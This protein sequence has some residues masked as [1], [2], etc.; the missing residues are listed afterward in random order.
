MAKVV[1]LDR[2]GVINRYPGDGNYVT[3]CRDFKLIPG[4]AE[5]IKKIKR[6]G[7]KIFVVSN[8]SGVAKGKYSEKTLKQINRRLNF[9]LWLRKTSIDAIYYCTHRN[10]DNCS[11]RKPKTGLLDKAIS[12]LEEKIELSFFIGDSFVDMVTA[13]N[14]GA[15]TILLLSGKEKLKNRKNW[16]F[17][18]DYIFDNLLLASNFLLNNYA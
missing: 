1:F 9:K 18:P 3:S 17:E 5:A 14:F 11:C 4:A 13:K 6:G 15:K 2:D 16:L 10:E 8:Q 7:F 12:S